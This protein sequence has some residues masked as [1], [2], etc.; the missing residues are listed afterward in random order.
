MRSIM[1]QK[2]ECYIC[3][4]TTD[5]QLHHCLHG[6]ANRK[7]ADEDGLTV[8]LCVKCHTD[9]H[10]HGYYDKDLQMRAMWKWCSYYGRTP[11]EFRQRYGKVIT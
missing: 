1:W 9:L 8:P 6:T 3:G 4:R 2:N 10:D 7:L 11:D 5:L